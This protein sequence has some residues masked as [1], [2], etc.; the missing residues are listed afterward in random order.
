MCSV[1]VEGPGEAEAAETL[2]SVTVEGLG[3]AEAAETLCSVTVEGPGEAEAAERRWKRE[4][5]RR[6]QAGVMYCRASR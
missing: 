5:E 4:G 2:C 6:S 1:T 3:E